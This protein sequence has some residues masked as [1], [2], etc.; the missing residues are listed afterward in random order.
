MTSKQES[1]YGFDDIFRNN[2]QNITHFP[3]TGCNFWKRIYG[4]ATTDF[5]L[6]FPRITCLIREYFHETMRDFSSLL[7]LWSWMRGRI[8]TSHRYKLSSIEQYWGAF[9]CLKCVANVKWL[10][11]FELYSLRHLYQ[12]PLDWEL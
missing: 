3:L 1:S 6:W 5:I 10:I 4:V 8:K 2:K 11:L 9:Y 12:D 7:Y